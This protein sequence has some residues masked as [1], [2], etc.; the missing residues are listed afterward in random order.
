MCGLT[1]FWCPWRRDDAERQI[2]AMTAALRHRGPDADKTWLDP[3]T[4]LALGHRRLAI[5]DLSERGAQPM[6]SACGRYVIV[7]NGEIYNHLSLREEL[8][9]TPHRAPNWRGTSDTETLLA[10]FVA[11]GVVPMLKKCVGMFAFALWDRQERR[12]ILARDRFGE[13]PLY[14]GWVGR[15][16]EAS[17]VFGSELKALRAMPGFD[18]AIDRDSVAL[19]LRFCYVPAPYT[20]YE[21]VSKLEPGTVLTLEAA[22]LG[23]RT[24]HIEPFWR[25]EDVAVAGLEDPILDEVEGLE[26][27]D[28]TLRDAVALQLVADVPVGAFLSGGIDSSAIVALMQAQSTRPVKTFTIGFDEAGFDEAPH[29]AAIAR[30]L[31]TDHQEVRVSARETRDVIPKLPATY[32]EPFADSSQIPTSVI[33]SVAR[34]QVTVALSGDGGDEV[35]G[36]YN[37]YLLGPAL[38]RRLAPIPPVVRMALGA[39]IQHMPAAGWGMLRSLPGL[40]RRLVPF[41]AK[42]HKIGPALA[43]MSNADDL[44]SSLVTEWTAD[45]VPVPRNHARPTKLD[46]IG[47]DGK[48]REPERRMMLLDAVSYLPDD[49]LVKVDRAAMAVSL[50]TRAPILDHRV[51]EIAWRLP[52]SMKIRDGLSKWALRQILYRHVPRSL[53]DRRKAG[54]AVP[55]GQWLRGPLSDWA[56]DL[57]SEHRLSDGYLDT[58]TTRSLWREHCSG[59][60][61]WTARL[62]NVLMFQS[63]LVSE[64]T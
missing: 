44:Y 10:G 1:G 12:L 7:L 6:H 62:W 9:Q 60:R 25:F 61:D 31:G 5:L 14:Y 30:H 11:W 13:K 3:E 53:V 64:R 34:Q 35:F 4:G 32:D 18:N 52:L 2:A 17:F 49:I 51:A 41:V 63:W 36:G 28:D 15:G 29:A 57:L 40:G 38:W 50:E 20:I 22:H 46:T 24:F 37:R 47:F 55:I 16:A 59:R 58:S 8:G 27:L 42:A 54:F 33:C 21:N 39:C 23:K 56:E 19:F 45:A 43:H 26:R 48:V